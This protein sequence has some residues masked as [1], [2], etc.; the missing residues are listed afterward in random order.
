M[1]IKTTTRL[2]LA[3]RDRY[4]M[5][6]RTIANMGWGGVFVVALML[7]HSMLKPVDAPTRAVLTVKQPAILIM[8]TT[9][10]PPLPTY[11]PLPIPTPV[12][13]EVPAPAPPPVVQFVE[14]P[15]NVYVPVEAVDTPEPPAPALQTFAQASDEEPLSPALMREAMDR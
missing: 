12:V 13:I 14:V 8:T 10:Q 5:H 3:I 6:E 1:T 15:V 2:R 4:L 7:I 9:P 11:T